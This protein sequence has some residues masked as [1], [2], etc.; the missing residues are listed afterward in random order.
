M[1]IS[2]RLPEEEYEKLSLEFEEAPPALSGKPGFL[3]AMR[4]RTLIAELLSPDYARI[5]YTKAKVMSL[6]PSEFIQHAIKAQ[7]IENA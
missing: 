7:L 2:D 5:V 3:T 4:E 6:S 1:R